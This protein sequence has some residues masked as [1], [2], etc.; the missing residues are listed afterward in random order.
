MHAQKYIS[1]ILGIPQ[2]DAH[3]L[4]LQIAHSSIHDTKKPLRISGLHIICAPS[5]M[6]GGV[7]SHLNPPCISG[8]TEEGNFFDWYFIEH[9][10]K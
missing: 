8:T 7:N 1:H 5:W 2:L 6:Q 4:L 3:I 10:T 9:L